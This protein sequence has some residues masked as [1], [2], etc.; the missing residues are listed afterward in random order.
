MIEVKIGLYTTKL[1]DEED[2]TILKKRIATLRHDLVELATKFKTTDQMVSISA[3]VM[4]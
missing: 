4:Y 3:T 2:I 1:T